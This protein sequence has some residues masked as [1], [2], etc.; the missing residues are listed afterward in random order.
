MKS[1]T[2]WKEWRLLLRINILEV[3]KSLL[4]GMC[5]QLH[6]IIGKRIL[7]AAKASETQWKCLII[8][9]PI[10]LQGMNQYPKDTFQIERSIK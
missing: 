8:D 3:T 1:I 4:I 2:S 5:T 6:K 9:E 10:V 7:K